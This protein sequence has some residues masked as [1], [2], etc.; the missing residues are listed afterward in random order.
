MVHVTTVKVSDEFKELVKRHNL[1]YSE[2]TR[3]GIAIQ[4]AELGVLP[5]DNN[6]NVMRRMEKLSLKLGETMQELESL[7]R[8]HDELSN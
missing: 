2:S 6:L 7:K 5:Y 3:I 1:H 8:K 4:L